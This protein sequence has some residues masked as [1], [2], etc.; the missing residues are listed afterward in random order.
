MQAKRRGT[1]VL[2]IMVAVL[3]VVPAAWAREAVVVTQDG[4]QFRGEVLLDN[5]KGVQLSI[6]GIT[7]MIAREDIRDVR[8]EVSVP[9]EFQA[10]RQALADDDLEGRYKLA[11]WL[12]ENKGYALAQRELADLS[13]RFPEDKRIGTLSQ[14]VET[15]MKIAAPPAEPRPD[16]SRPATP[17]TSAAP[18]ALLGAALSDLPMLNDEQVNM[19][20]VYEIDMRQRPQPRVQIPREVITDF[21][22]KYAGEDNNPNPPSGLSLRGRQNE[23]AFR[24]AAPQQQLEKMFEL[25]ARDFYPL[26]QVRDDPEALMVFRRDI[27]RQ[28][29]LNFCGTNRCH[30]GNPEA[31]SFVL[32]PSRPTSDP[33]VYTNFYILHR[34]EGA[35]GYMIDRERPE[36]S[37]LVQY[38][39]ARGEVRYPHPDV[40]GFV[41]R[42]TARDQNVRE[43]LLRWIGSLYRPRPT[44]PISY[45]PPVLRPAAPGDAAAPAVVPAPATPANPPPAAPV[46]RP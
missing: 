19:I 37:F 25:Q 35:G 38:G 11:L 33:T 15:R 31:G 29:V 28:Y 4:R 5:E 13:V 45:E 30:G 7:T 23:I 17:A 34:W 40:P 39:M 14:I 18:G 1:F 26:V 36:E 6:A 2:M 27:H 10:R 9:E 41:P 46:N 43:A 24:R 20:R 3:C 12:F 32:F 16:P 8:Y 42:L 22:A 21:I 44:Y